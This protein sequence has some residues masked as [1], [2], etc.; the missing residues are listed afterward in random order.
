MVYTDG[1]HLVADDLTELHQ[2]AEKIYLKKSWFKDHDGA[3]HY[4]VWGNKAVLA[5]KRGAKLVQSNRIIAIAASLGTQE[6]CPVKLKLIQLDA[7]LRSDGYFRN[8]EPRKMIT[9]IKN[10]LNE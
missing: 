5:I 7:I 2:F 8:S 9:E 4:E 1:Q 6:A 10:M 3:P